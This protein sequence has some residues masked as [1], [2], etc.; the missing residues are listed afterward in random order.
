MTFA[1]NT[2]RNLFFSILGILV[3]LGLQIKSCNKINELVEGTIVSADTLRVYRDILDREHTSIRNY[4]QSNKEAL[5]SLRS[6]DST[7]I[8]LQESVKEYRGKL[9]AAIVLSNRTGVSGSGSTTI[10]KIDTVIQNDSILLF[11]TYDLTW[12]DKWDR[13]TIKAMRDSV[14]Y[15]IETKNEYELTIGKPSNGL[16]KKRVSEVSV[17]NLN[18]KTYTSE[19]RSFSIEHKPKKLGLDIQVGYG[20]SSGFAPTPYIGVGLGYRLIGIK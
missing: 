1:S 14:F 2:H 3:L 16:F 15:A 19:L 12:D 7:I 13:G 5:L 8:W 4:A 17:V 6:A 18:P 10:S 11:P 9:D 20:F